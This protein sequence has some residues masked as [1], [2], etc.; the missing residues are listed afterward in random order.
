MGIIP[1]QLLFIIFF[2]LVLFGRGRI[3]ISTLIISLGAKNRRAVDISDPPAPLPAEYQPAVHAL[4]KLGFRRLGETSVTVSG[5]QAVKSRVFVSADNVV[6]AELTEIKMPIW[7]LTTAYP[8]DAAVETGF[9]CGENI[10]TADFRS[11]TITAD[12]GKAYRHQ[13]Q[14]LEAFGKTHGAPRRIETMQDY[15]SW[16]ALYRERYVLRKMRR[17]LWI[18]LADLFFLA[19]AIA[20]SAAAAVFWWAS[21]KSTAAPLM[22]GLFVFLDALIPAVAAAAAVALIDYWG[23]RRESKSI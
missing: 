5:V 10:E 2:L 17:F 21:D 16:D 6:L 9:P 11:H 22:K 15:L 23:G 19:Y 12:L 14:Q 7:T 4:S 1:V 20:V 8:D 3:G 18:S 13:V